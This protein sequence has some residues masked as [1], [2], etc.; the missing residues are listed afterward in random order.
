[1]LSELCK[2]API[3]EVE[4][5]GCIGEDVVYVRTEI[6]DDYRF[7]PVSKIVEGV[8]KTDEDS[9][10][11]APEEFDSTVVNLQNAYGYSISGM[12]IHIGT[13]SVH[14]YIGNK[15]IDLT[16]GVYELPIPLDRNDPLKF[17]ETITTVAHDTEVATRL[18]GN[19]EFI[20]MLRFMVENGQKIPR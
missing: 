16:V 12:E 7:D 19:E 15:G 18:L 4:F 2:L 5:F 8:M 17:S 10:N 14:V 3:T 13:S 1:M 11:V 20:N 9:Y 6:Q